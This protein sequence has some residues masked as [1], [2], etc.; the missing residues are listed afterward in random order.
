MIPSILRFQPIY[1]E[2]IWGGRGLE[3]TL[4]RKIPEGMVGETWEISDYG[5]DRSIILDGAWKGRDFRSVYKMY[6]R[7]VLG[8]GMEGLPFPL[9]VKIIDAQEKLSVQVHPSDDYARK[10]DPKNTGKKEAW[11]VLDCKP[12]ATLTI[13]FNKDLD[14][15]SYKKLVESNKAES[16]LK[17]V[18]VSPGDAFL[19]E[20]GTVHAIGAGV[21]LL[22]IQQSADSTYRVYDYGRPRDLHLER[23]L[24]VLNFK[25]SRGKE[26][27]S[28]QETDFIG[29]GTLYRLTEN[30]KFRIYVL[31]LTP[32]DNFEPEDFEP[33]DYILPALTKKPRFHIYS[34]LD[35]GIRLSTGEEFQKGDSFLATAFGCEKEILFHA[36][37]NRPPKIAIS[38][39][40]SLYD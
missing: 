5:D 29:A 1:K 32:N 27:L 25:K 39:V 4:A 21:I 31:D 38:T 17:D 36:Q 35:G 34:L 20:P 8:S 19:I 11:I 23:A 30:D 33:E 14:R 6:P 3:K 28:Y 22:E 15:D 9:L 16:V 37:G 10:K 13:G 24:D 7:E 40:G 18:P 2:K 26:S 12:G